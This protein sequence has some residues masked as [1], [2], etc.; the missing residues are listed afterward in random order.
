LLL[1]SLYALVLLGI[2][3]AT[4][5]NDPMFW[6]ASPAN[7]IQY[8][9]IILAG[10][11]VL[12]L[13]TNPPRRMWLRLVTGTVAGLVGMWTIQQTF[14]GSLQYLDILA[15]SSTSLAV[16]ITALER[17]A[18]SMAPYSMSKDNQTAA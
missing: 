12:Q 11:L 10:I 13:I 17:T 1:L 6:L 16:L 3:T 4:M 15:F 14:N 9:R 5:S 7:Y 18:T 8:I 2:G